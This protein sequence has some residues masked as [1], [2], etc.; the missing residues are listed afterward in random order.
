MRLKFSTI[1]TVSET[2]RGEMNWKDLNTFEPNNLFQRIEA[3][4]Q[5]GFEVLMLMA[6]MIPSAPQMTTCTYRR[7]HRAFTPAI[8]GCCRRM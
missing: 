1:F 7:A 2:T 5:N 4:R 8:T 3:L 6:S